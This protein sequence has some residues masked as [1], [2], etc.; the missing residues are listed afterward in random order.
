M[1][2]YKCERC[3]KEF[4]QKCHYTHHINKK[5]PCKEVP[6][7]PTQNPQKT[8]I[9]E[10]SELTCKHCGKDFSRS[11]SLKRHIGGYCKAIKANDAKMEEMMTMLIELKES[12][13]ELKESDKHNKE[14]MKN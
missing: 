4:D 11:D 3:L 6:Q 5:F 13:R 1:P 14:T 2:N 10:K 12:D 8:T 9:I 7:N